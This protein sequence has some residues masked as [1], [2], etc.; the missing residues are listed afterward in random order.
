MSV[1]DNQPTNRNF[2]S[3]LGFKF[4]IK[5]LPNTNYFV[6]SVNLP[7]ITLGESGED[8]PFVRIPVPGD[9]LVYS[10]LI[11]QFR[12]DED[13][14]NYLELHNWLTGLGFP[15]G[16]TQYKTLE[17]QALKEQGS[18]GGI[19]SDGSLIILDS[20]MNP[21]IQIDF[22]DMY[23]TSLTDLEFSSISTDVDYVV[24]TAGF[25]YKIYKITQL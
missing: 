7:A 4:Q 10:D 11:L 1:L 5:K 12:V 14:Q 16:F 22:Q 25:R 3:Q 2:L 13:F 8:N 9:H 21:N 24:C 23:I 19:Y 17:D 18:G 20:A 15:E 6:Q